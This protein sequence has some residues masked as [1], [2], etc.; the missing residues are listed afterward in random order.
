MRIAF[1]ELGHIHYKFGFL[2]DSIKAWNKSHDFSQS[3]EDLFN[4][5]FQIAQVSFEIQNNSYLMKYSGEADARDKQKDP[6]K[7]MII[8]ILDSLSSLQFDNMKQASLKLA[9]VSLT[10]DQ[11]I[12]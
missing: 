5:A 6:F 12:Y 1:L 4:I 3:E 9:S 8:K 2:N 11:R 10:D 7:T